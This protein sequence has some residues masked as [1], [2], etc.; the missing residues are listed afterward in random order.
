METNF[1]EE[2]R[3]VLDV[4]RQLYHPDARARAEQ[5]TAAERLR[6]HQAESGPLMADLKTWMRTKLDAHEVEPNSGLGDAIEYMLDHWEPL[7][8][9]LRVAGAPLDNNLCERALKKAIRHRRNSLFYKTENGARVGDMFM[10]LI[11][12]AELNG[13][14]PFDY[15]VALMRHP[16]EVAREPSHWMPWNY[17]DA[18]ATL[19][20]APG[21]APPTH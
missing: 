5:M 12:T 21:A 10:S 17:R 14:N 2:C 6:F 20:V 13:A 4:F 11:H 8:L 9:F 7:T 18:L 3:H 16:R 19:G 1:P 15:L